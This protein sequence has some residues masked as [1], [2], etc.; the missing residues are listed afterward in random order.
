MRDL[1]EILGVS[2]SAQDD[3]IKKAYRK[4]AKELHPDRNPGNKKA[5]DRFKEVTVAHE[6]LSHKDKRKLYDEFGA[7][8]LQSGFNPEMARA[9]RSGRA[10]ANPFAGGFG[11][12]GVTWE[13]NGDVDLS[14]IFEQMFGGRGVGGFG[15]FSS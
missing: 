4:L 12:Q 14:S 6:V 10:N 1:Y 8:S 3:E 5:E 11:G 2:K 9:I 15:G 7:E 13:S